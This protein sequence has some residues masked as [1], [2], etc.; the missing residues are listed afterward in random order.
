MTDSAPMREVKKSPGF[1]IWLSW[2]TK[3]HARVKTFSSSSSKT[4]L[5]EKISR[6]ISPL[7]RLIIALYRDSVVIGIIGFLGE[8]LGGAGIQAKRSQSTSWRGRPAA[9]AALR[10]ASTMGGGPHR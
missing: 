6:L 5:L 10:P 3:S 2:P 4:S 9:S 1:G 7:R 8:G